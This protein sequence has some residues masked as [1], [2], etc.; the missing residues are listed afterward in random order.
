MEHINSNESF[1]QEKLRKIFKPLIL[2]GVILGSCS[3]ISYIKPY[4]Y[5]TE[6]KTGS[7]Y[8]ESKDLK[9]QIDT[10][11]CILHSFN[12][13]NFKQSYAPK[14]WKVDNSVI[15]MN[16]PGEYK[17][18][19]EIGVN[20]QKEPSKEIQWKIDKKGEN[21]ITLSAKVGGFTII[22]NISINGYKISVSD[23]C[24]SDKLQKFIRIYGSNQNNGSNF[25]LG[26]SVSKIFREDSSSKS[27]FRSKNVTERF[28]MT[29]DWVSAY[30]MDKY[31]VGFRFKEDD[32]ISKIEKGQYNAITA[33][34]FSEDSLEIVAAPKDKEFLKNTEFQC[35]VSNDAWFPFLVDF[36]SYSLDFLTKNFGVL[37]FLIFPLQVNLLSVLSIYEEIRKKRRE[38]SL[39]NEIAAA[40]TK[41]HHNE[42]KLNLE[43][44]EI[45]S[46]YGKEKMGHLF[47]IEKATFFFLFSYCMKYVIPGCFNLSKMSFLWVKDLSIGDPYNIVNLFGLLNFEPWAIFKIGF[48]SFLLVFSMLL[49]L[50]EEQINQFKDQKYGWL[51]LIGGLILVQWLKMS[52]A[53]IIFITIFFSF[54]NIITNL[55]MYIQDKKRVTRI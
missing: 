26:N 30:V 48:F 37:G 13:K 16:K 22:R 3:I 55:V 38:I 9:V 10:R 31:F 25:F 51:I 33:F 53:H 32:S 7:T 11:G 23:S 41:Y 40:R 35:I 21:F 2:L 42:M 29:P 15:L 5:Y 47:F 6:G 39:E 49:G 34:G 17:E 18:C 12:L 8:L 27:F 46:K 50:S 19:V 28:A 52:V 54:K 14:D 45:K 1:W 20:F 36:L 4:R 44:S 24:P 43:I